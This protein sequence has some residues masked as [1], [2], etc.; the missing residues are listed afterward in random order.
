MDLSNHPA[1]WY[2]SYRRRNK[3]D[4]VFLIFVID[5]L[6]GIA[7]LILVVALVASIWLVHKRLPK[8]TLS[9]LSASQSVTAASTGISID[10]LQRIPAA[11]KTVPQSPDPSLFVPKDSESVFVALQSANP[12]SV[13]LIGSAVGFSR[14]SADNN[15]IVNSHTLLDASWILRL[16]PSA[17]IIQIGASTDLSSLKKFIPKSNTEDLIAVYTYTQTLSGNPVYGIATGVYE[18]NEAASLAAEHISAQSESYLP[19]IRQVA[20]LAAEI[21][22]MNPTRSR[23]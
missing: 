19:W 5:T 7:K 16:N 22:K 11:S 6:I 20:D 12:A 9:A 2:Q 3:Y 17:H 8:N 21:E 10:P 15:A 1:A 4:K 14:T 23:D 18:S 13:Q